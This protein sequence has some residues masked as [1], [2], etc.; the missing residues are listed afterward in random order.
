MPEK[1]LLIID[2]AHSH[3]KINEL[4]VNENFKVLF[5]PPNCTAILQPMDQNIIQNIKVNYRKQLLQ[6]LLAETSD[7][8]IEMPTAIK[9]YNIRNAVINLDDSWKKITETNIIRNWLLLWP[10]LKQLWE[11]DDDIP[12]TE[13]R[14]MLL[15][16]DTSEISELLQAIDP[17]ASLTS[18]EIRNWASGINENGNDQFEEGNS[19]SNDDD[20]GS[21]ITI[22]DNPESVSA[23]VALASLITFVKWAQ[24]ND[25][26]VTEVDCLKGL[27]QKAKLKK[28][29]SQTQTKIINYFSKKDKN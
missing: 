5:L 18:N 7:G 12:L 15:L 25:A 14:E 3:P 9:K 28:F 24:Y 1:A 2:N 20:Y 10:C 23:D 11:P 19:S 21:N 17:Q 16:T 22:N 8:A 27:L 13:L 6:Y 29:R 26:S 4:S